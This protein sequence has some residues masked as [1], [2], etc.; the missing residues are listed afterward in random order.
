MAPWR[1]LSTALVTRV[2]RRPP[3]G[4][5]PVNDGQYTT[6]ANTVVL[7]FDPVALRFVSQLTVG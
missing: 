1:R 2:H 3:N 4:N 5:V 7:T 6:G